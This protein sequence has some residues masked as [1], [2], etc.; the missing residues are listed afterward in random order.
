MKKPKPIK[1]SRKEIRKG[2][3]KPMPRPAQEHEDKRRKLIEKLNARPEES[4]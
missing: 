4:D 1:L 3:R 2:V